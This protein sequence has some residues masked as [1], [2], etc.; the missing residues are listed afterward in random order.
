M[1]KF[2]LGLN[3]RSATNRRMATVNVMGF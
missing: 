3:N 2:P 1:Q